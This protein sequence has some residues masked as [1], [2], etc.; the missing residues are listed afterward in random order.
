MQHLIVIALVLELPGWLSS[1]LAAEPADLPM[2]VLIGDS[3]RLSYAPIVERALDGQAVVIQAKANGGD[4]S[5]VLKHLGE[6]AVAHQPD[7]VHFNCGIHDTK[8]DKATGD[9]QVSPEQYEANLRAIVAMLRRET[10]ATILFAT[11]TPI[12]DDRAAARRGNAAYELL[13]ASTVEYN[14][15]AV[16]VMQE[17]EVPVDD[18][19]AACGN[20]AEREQCISDDGVHFTPEGRERLGKTVTEF[21]SQHLEQVAGD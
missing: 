8:R 13:D 11:T 20:E 4:S 6:W 12:L 14:R 2:V 1:T 10:Q 15:I 19:R 3:I 16:R 5:N 17:L 9:F 7:I 18:L 21:I